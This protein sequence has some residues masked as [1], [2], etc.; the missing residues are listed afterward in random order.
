LPQLTEKARAA[1]DRRSV[2]F[3][4]TAYGLLMLPDQPGHDQPTE[5]AVA[6]ERTEGGEAPGIPQRLTGR[7]KSARSWVRARP[8][9]ARIWRGAVALAGLVVIVV[10]IVLLAAPGPGWLIIF[11]G[12]GIWATE[13]AW[14]KSLLRFARRTVARWTAWLGRQPRWL[15]VLLGAAGLLTLGAVVAGAWLVAT[16]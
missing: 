4:V 10:G 9:G 14:A 11:L 12:L 16:Q 7:M 13:F 6:P 8:G 3:R 2:R 15:S 5:P 1:A